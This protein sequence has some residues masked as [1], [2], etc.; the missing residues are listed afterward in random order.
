MSETDEKAKLMS[1][2][3]STVDVIAGL[4]ANDVQMDLLEVAAHLLT[5]I[6]FQVS[7]GCSKVGVEETK[8]VVQPMNPGDKCE[9]NFSRAD[10]P[11]SDYWQR[12]TVIDRRTSEFEGE[13]TYE[14]KTTATNRD[15]W[16]GMANV[17]KPK[18]G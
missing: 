3:K 1:R 15:T 10:G 6:L 14:Y 9:V 5:N 2:I 13:K 17:R 16:I 4:P 12:A 8:P 7:K 18:E 11:H